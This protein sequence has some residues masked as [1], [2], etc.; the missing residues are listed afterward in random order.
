MIIS[1]LNFVGVPKATLRT[2]GQSSSF[3]VKNIDVISDTVYF[4]DII[5]ESLLN[6]SEIT[7]S[8]VNLFSWTEETN[9]QIKASRNEVPSSLPSIKACGRYFNHVGTHM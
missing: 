5:L 4:R 2:H 6:V 8:Y 9:V 7:K 1:N 3:K